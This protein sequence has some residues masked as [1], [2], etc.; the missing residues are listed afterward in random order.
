MKKISL[1]LF[2]L[3]LTYSITA[4]TLHLSLPQVNV[5][6]GQAI[7]LPLTVGDF[8][9]IVSVQLSI[10][11]NTEIAVFDS[12]S[13]AALP[14]LAVG[15]FQAEQG[16]LRISWFDN[17]GNGRS[18]E[19][20][21]VIANL[22]FTAMGDIG[23]FTDLLFTDSPLEI[24]VFKATSTP[25]VFNPVALEPT[26]GRITIGEAPSIGFMIDIQDVSCVGAADGSLT[27]SLEV[28]PDEYTI[29]WQGP[30]DFEA[31][32]YALEGLAGGDYS[33]IIRDVDGQEVF[34]Y[35][36]TLLEASNPP[37]ALLETDF[38]EICPGDSLQLKLSGG[39]FYQWLEG[40]DF[41]TD[42]TI[43]DPFAFPD[44]TTSFVVQAGNACGFDTLSFDVM[45]FEVFATAGQ[46]TCIGPGTE[47]R[48]NANGGIFYQWID[49]TSTLNVTNIRNPIASPK[50][51]TTYRVIITDINDCITE[52]EITVL[53]ANNPAEI[54][55]AYDLISPNGDGKNDVLDFDSI[56]KFGPNSLK[57]YNRWGD[58]IYQKTNYQSD[59]ERFDGTFKNEPLPAG[60]Y[61][62]VLTFQQGTIK[63]TLTIIREN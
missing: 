38:P 48:L 58:L 53:V 52:D 63:Q 44:T 15:D 20:G 56:S 1:G 35:N 30:D 22:S 54:V 43:A 34:N 41:L 2:F 42:A 4:Q 23:D 16:E 8:D 7:T 6:D 19:E 39:V 40:Q 17:T 47:L 26:T 46:D 21:T 12:F 24:Q 13:L 37:I 10:N 61:F 14:L 9:S 3:A 60:N 45:V 55:V 18:L 59:E 49:E 29:E 57:V 32:S 62:Y 28:N 27:V 31:S 33:L 25:G 5:D 50:D 51:S 11:W 36:L